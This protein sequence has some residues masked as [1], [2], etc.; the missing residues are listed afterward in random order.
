M[1]ENDKISA[2][3]KNEWKSN[4]LRKEKHTGKEKKEKER[5]K[6]DKGKETNG[7]TS[8]FST[9][10]LELATTCGGVC[11]HEK[12]EISQSFAGIDSFHSCF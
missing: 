12:K 3:G 9:T 1:K 7:H 11:T 4:T 2:E 5:D 10:D 6:E 8:M